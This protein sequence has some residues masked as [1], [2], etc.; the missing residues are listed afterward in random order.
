V[1]ADRA[2]KNAEENIAVPPNIHVN[3][4]LRLMFIEAITE[5]LYTYKSL[6][7]EWINPSAAVYVLP[8][9]LRLYVTR[10][11]N[12]FNILHPSG[13]VA[14]RTCSYAEWE[15]R[16]IAY[17]IMYEVV[18]R[19]PSLANIVGEKCRHLGF[20]PERTWCPI[21]LKY[22]HYDEERHKAFNR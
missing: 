11:Y 7:D 1:A 4:R 2:L 6:T 21:I 9:A 16:A 22:H 14:M 19:V 5:S 8:Q 18:R 20:C 12:G 13:Y 17:K 10:L 15:Q 3:E